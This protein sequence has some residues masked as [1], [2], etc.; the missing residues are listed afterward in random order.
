M[1]NWVLFILVKVMK[2]FINSDV[3]V[4]FIYIMYNLNEDFM[5]VC[6]ELLL[7]LRS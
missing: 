1:F 2:Y 3:F 7:F 5:Y 6:R 4:I